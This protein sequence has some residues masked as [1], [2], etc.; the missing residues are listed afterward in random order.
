MVMVM[1]NGTWQLVAD[2]GPN[3]AK[4]LDGGVMGAGRWRWGWW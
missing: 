4:R 3:A 2:H 1:A